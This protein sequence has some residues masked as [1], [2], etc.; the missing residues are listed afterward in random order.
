MNTKEFI[1]SKLECPVCKRDYAKNYMKVHLQ[2]QHKNI[3]GTPQW[4]N[5]QYEVR[6]QNIKEKHKDFFKELFSEK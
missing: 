6:F 2:K 3:F 1:N 4:K 5:S